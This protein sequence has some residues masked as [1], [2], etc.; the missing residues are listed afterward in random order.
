MWI[1]A[2]YGMFATLIIS[3]SSVFARATDDSDRACNGE[4]QQISCRGENEARTRHQYCTDPQHTPP[5]HAIRS[6]REPQR[7]K[8]VTYQRKRKQDARLEFT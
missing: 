4:K 3:I 1:E 7:D 8:R 2:V 5:A 6:G